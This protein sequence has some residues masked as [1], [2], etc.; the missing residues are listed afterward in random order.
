MNRIAFLAFTL[1]SLVLTNAFA[2]NDPA[3]A[4]EQTIPGSSIVFKMVPIPSGNFSIGSPDNEKGRRP[5]EGP[6]KRTMVPAFWM[7]EH[8]VTYDEFLLFLNDESTSRNSDIDAVT[9]PTPQYVDLSWGM[10][11]QGGFP[12]NSM[13]QHSAL[14]YCRWLYKKTGQF[15]RLPTEAEWEYAARAGSNAPY[16]FGEDVKKLKEFAWFA[17]NSKEKFQKVMQKKPNPWGL[18]DILGN[19]AEWTLDQYDENFYQSITDS[20]KS[21]VN[22]PTTRYPRSV[23]GGGFEDAAEGLRCAARSKSEAAWNRRDPQIP[24]SKWWLTEAKSVGFRIIR[25][26]NQPSATDI[27]LFYDHFLKDN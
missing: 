19:V 22:L 7:G 23:R 16:F 18:Y 3:Q 8:E 27:E 17:E 14:M 15:Y 20:T 25:P 6:V 10:G 2:Q 13:S 11:K 26:V 1:C 5:D 21:A 24:K 9:R 4:Y 12:I